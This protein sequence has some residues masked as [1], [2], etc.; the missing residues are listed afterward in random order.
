MNI[1]IIGGTGFVGQAVVERL[2]AD[3]HQ[4]RLL[5]RPGSGGK[6]PTHP[7]CTLIEGRLE[8]SESLRN[9]ITGSDAVIYLVGLLREN[10]AA[11][12]TFEQLQFRGVEASIAAAK[13][14]GVARFLLMSANGIDAGATPYQRTKLRAEAALKRSGLEWS[15]F[16]PS[17][18][19]GDPRGRMEFCTQ[20]K[21]ELIDSPVP[22][23][24]FYEGLLP[25][26]A[27]QFRLGPVWVGDVA[28]AFAAA[29][30]QPDTSGQTYPLCGPDAV[31]WKEILATIAAASGKK[32]TML[33][34]P[35]ML[36]APVAAVMERFQWFP[37]TRDQLRMLVA[38]NC[39]AE[40]G[41]ARLGL[42]PAPF[43]T[44]ALD[45]LA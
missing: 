19:F 36:I 35:V 9:C 4:L 44:A 25:R 11:G 39:C 20:L 22:A 41:F 37:V 27:G 12:I 18:I 21:A 40:D 32:K 17:V 16:R 5:A 31:S 7:Q 1:S 23:P 15:I 29:L 26:K 6:A 13:E 2:L 38:G 10:A 24:L 8:D 28:A 14:A 30:T 3:G 43:N 33:P 42:N 45:Y 34:A